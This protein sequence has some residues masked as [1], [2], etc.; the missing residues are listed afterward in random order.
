MMSSA[1]LAAPLNGVIVAPV[2]VV[3][4]LALLL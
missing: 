1:V 4:V 2:D 3:V